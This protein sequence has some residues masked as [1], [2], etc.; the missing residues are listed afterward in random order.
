MS[1]RM[2]EEHSAAHLRQSVIRRLRERGARVSLR[3]NGVLIVSNAP[4]VVFE[5]LDVLERQYFRFTRADESW[6][7]RERAP[8]RRRSRG[9]SCVRKRPAW[10]PRAQNVMSECTRLDFV[11]V[12]ARC[13]AVVFW[14]TACVEGL[15]LA[16]THFHPRSANAW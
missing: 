1:S 15:S 9:F 12:T 6:R 3:S 14:Y 11:Y 2:H 8:R 16:S 7:S 5:V 4:T 13:H 10:E